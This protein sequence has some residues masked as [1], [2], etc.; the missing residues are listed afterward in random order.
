MTADR[1]SQLLVDNKTL[2]PSYSAASIK[3]INPIIGV[4]ISIS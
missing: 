4:S 1:V 3:L 2:S